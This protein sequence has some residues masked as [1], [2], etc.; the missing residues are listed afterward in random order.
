MSLIQYLLDLDPAVLAMGCVRA[1]PAVVRACRVL[2]DR[3]RWHHGGMTESDGEM[4]PHKPTCG[5]CGAVMGDPEIHTAW[6]AG[7]DTADARGAVLDFLDSIDVGAL[8]KAAL[9]G[10]GLGKDPIALALEALKEEAAK[11]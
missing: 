1:L 10:G 5:E 2:Y 8:H 11:L 3:G 4:V 6:H 9:S 7:G